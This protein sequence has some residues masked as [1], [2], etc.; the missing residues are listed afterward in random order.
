MPR[1]K[2]QGVEREVDAGLGKR[3]EFFCCMFQGLPSQGRQASRL[4]KAH[5]IKL[6]YDFTITTGDT[7][8]YFHNF[9]TSTN[10]GVN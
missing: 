7:K 2:V 6:N 1:E 5:E 4:E 8:T 9:Q 3:Q 10:K